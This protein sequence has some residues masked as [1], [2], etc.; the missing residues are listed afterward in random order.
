MDSGPQA[1]KES[2]DQPT[3][4]GK[5]APKKKKGSVNIQY[6]GVPS[7]GGKRKVSVKP[8]SACVKRKVIIQEYTLFKLFTVY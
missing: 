2:V 5:T 8:P 4:C 6:P 7:P 1:Q 3:S